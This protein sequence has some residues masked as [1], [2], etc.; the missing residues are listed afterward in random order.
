MPHLPPPELLATTDSLSALVDWHL[1]NLLYEQ[2][3]L[4]GGLLY[5][6]SFTQH[7]VFGV[8]PCCGL[9]QGAVPSRAE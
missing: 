7:H 9:R 5:L 4:P 1:L 3:H 2:K 8:Y 6:A